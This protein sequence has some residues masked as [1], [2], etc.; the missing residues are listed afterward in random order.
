MKLLCRLL[1]FTHI[2]P[3]FSTL[4]FGREDARPIEFSGVFH[5]T[6]CSKSFLSGCLMKCLMG[7]EI[8]LVA[9]SCFF[10]FFKLSSVLYICF[11]LRNVLRGCESSMK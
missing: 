11:L 1:G 4:S 2:I 7:C 9:R 5:T 3:R 10:V 6:A 8:L